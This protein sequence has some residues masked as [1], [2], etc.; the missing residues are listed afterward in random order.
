MARKRNPLRDGAYR[1]WL[2]SNKEKLLKDI[3]EELGVSP[4][5]VRKWKSEDK[6]SGETNR[7]VTIQCEVMTTQKVIQVA[8]LLRIIRTL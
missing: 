3:A 6:W 2:E 7:S 5:T 1:I 4:S 8:E